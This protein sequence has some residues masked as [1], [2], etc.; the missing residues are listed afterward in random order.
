MDA[1]SSIKSNKTP[2]PQ[3]AILLSKLNPETLRVWLPNDRVNVAQIASTEF[4][5]FAPK[6]G[7][8]RSLLFALFRDPDFRTLMQG[9]VT[10]TSKSHQRISP[11]ALLAQEVLSADQA[12]FPAFASL[13]E[14]M[15]ERLL[16]SRAENQSLAETRDYLLP[17]LMSGTVRVVPQDRAA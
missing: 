5:V 12:L 7:A 10:G 6:A 3:G 8:S 17:R 15:L 4:L 1:G 14:P 9:M 13:V 2:V 16:A 11:P